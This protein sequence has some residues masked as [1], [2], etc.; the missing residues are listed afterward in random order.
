MEQYYK[1]A[2]LFGM[3]GECE[4][5]TLFVVDQRDGEYKLARDVPPPINDIPRN[6]FLQIFDGPPRPGR[7]ESVELVPDIAIQDRRERALRRLF[8]VR[9][10]LERRRELR[11][12]KRHS[13]L[14]TNCL[15]K[16]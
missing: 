8:V 2:G 16:E 14:F 12:T 6:A 7:T 15:Y 9:W 11:S 10:I 4:D 13:R 1:C 5:D 3:T